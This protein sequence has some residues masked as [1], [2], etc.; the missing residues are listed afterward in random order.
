MDGD[1]GRS[2]GDVG[3]PELVELVG[4]GI[5]QVQ[6]DLQPGQ[7]PG[8]L[9]ADM[10]DAEDRDHR[11]GRQRFQQQRDLAAA[12]LPAVLDCGRAR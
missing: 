6:L 11:P 1:I 4:A 10:A 9:V 7:D 5:D 12:A 3:Q 8:Q 2:A